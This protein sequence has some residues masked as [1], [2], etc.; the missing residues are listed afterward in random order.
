ME[1]LLSGRDRAGAGQRAI[2][3]MFVLLALKWVGRR[4]SPNPT[5]SAQLNRNG[6]TKVK[7]S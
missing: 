6:V 7:E 1:I 5:L 3:V 2:V 4:L